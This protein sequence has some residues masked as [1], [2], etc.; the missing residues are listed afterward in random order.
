MSLIFDALLIAAVFFA[1]HSWQTR[2]LPIDQPAPATVLALLDG[3]GIQAA[4]TTGEVGV[5]YFFAPWCFY[6]RHSIGNLD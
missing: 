2:N 5:V 6:C 4:V 1:V 3:T